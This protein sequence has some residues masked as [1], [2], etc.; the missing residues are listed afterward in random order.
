MSLPL[1]ASLSASFSLSLSLSLF[2]F[3][4]NYLTWAFCDCYGPTSIFGDFIDLYCQADLN[5]TAKFADSLRELQTA[6]C[7]AT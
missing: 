5:W 4:F 6:A 3:L 7:N 2:V 1:S